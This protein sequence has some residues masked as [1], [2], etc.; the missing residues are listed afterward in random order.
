MTFFSASTAEK[1]SN[2]S[3]TGRNRFGT[4]RTV[5]MH[6][7][8]QQGPACIFWLQSTGH[9]TSL[10]KLNDAQPTMWLYCRRVI[11][12]AGGKRRSRASRTQSQGDQKESLWISTS[13]APTMSLASLR[14][15]RASPCLPP[16][17]TSTSQ[18]LQPSC[19]ASI[20]EMLTQRFAAKDQI[21]FLLH[22]LLCPL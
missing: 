4:H 22:R 2:S 21:K 1:C 10:P 5:F 3:T 13:Q 11:L 18:S 20:L 7:A 19:A 12:R 15:L 9:Y 8:R 14:G 16:Q 6:R 17:V